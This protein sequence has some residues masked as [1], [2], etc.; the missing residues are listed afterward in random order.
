VGS[1]RTSR[2]FFTWILRACMPSIVSPAGVKNHAVDRR[3]TREMN[4]FE[5]DHLVP[6]KRINWKKNVHCELKG[7]GQDRTPHSSVDRD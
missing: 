4:L 7:H 1:S 6:W 2:P 5:A 3:R